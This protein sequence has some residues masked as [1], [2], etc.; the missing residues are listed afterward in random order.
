[1]NKGFTLIEIGLVL[2]IMTILLGLNL[3]DLK[4]AHDGFALRQSTDM[5]VQAMRYARSRAVAEGAVMMVT[6]AGDTFRLARAVEDE[7]GEAPARST[8]LAGRMGRIMRLSDGIHFADAPLQISFFP[9]GRIEPAVFRLAGE[10]RAFVI[11]TR[12][13]PGHVSW[14]EE[15]AP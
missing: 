12:E 3:P 2:V 15:N 7:D 5:V 6:F 1:V 4:R 9:D 14:L 11:S 8:P 13:Q 10:R